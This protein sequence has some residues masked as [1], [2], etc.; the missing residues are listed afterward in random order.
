[1]QYERKLTHEFFLVHKSG[2]F[3]KSHER[4]FCQKLCHFVITY[5]TASSIQYINRYKRVSLFPI[6]F[7]LHIVILSV[8]AQ[9]TS[10]F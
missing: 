7:Y 9:I 4:K 1:M 3:V 2:N 10:C 8:T 6:E 5:S